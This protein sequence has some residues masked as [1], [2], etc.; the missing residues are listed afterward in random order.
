MNVKINF[1]EKIGAIKPM[2]GVGQPP[3]FGT[4]FSMFRYLKDAGIPYS[5][6]HDVGGPYGGGRWVDIPNLF[7][8]FEADPYDESSYD[9]TFTDLLISALMENGVEPFFRL[10][11]TIETS[12]KIK[13]YRISPPKDFQKW[14]VIC[15]HVIRHYTEGWADGFKYDIKYW[16]IWNEPDNSDLLIENQMWQGTAEQFYEL[17]DVASRHLKKCFPHLYIG[18]YASC[19]FYA[20]TDTYQSL[21]LSRSRVQYFMDFF[22]NFLAYIKKTGAPLDFFSWHTYDDNIENNKVY[23]KYARQ[24]LDEEGFEKT[25]VSVNEWNSKIAKRGTAEHAAHV[26]SIMLIFQEL[27]IDM[28]MFYDARCGTSLYGSLFSP[29][30]KLPFPAYYSFVAFNELYK[31]G[32]QVRICSDIPDGLYAIA[33]A[34]EKDGCIVIANTLEEDT[35]LEL[36]AELQ[37]TECRIICDGKNLEAAQLGGIIPKNSVMLIKVSKRSNA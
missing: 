11:V 18:G 21:S 22:N 23:A 31:R 26:M 36:D 34:A 32:T 4:N 37:V 15:E 12:V 6:L 20:L 24:R 13:H 8:D 25:L 14:A 17:Y 28:A 2:H 5:R 19:G 35:P 29:L 16:E 3:F 30:D 27:P 9:F 10:G 1:D 33:A 7:R